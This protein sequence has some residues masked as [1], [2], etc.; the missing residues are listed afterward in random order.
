M[1]QYFIAVV[2]ATKYNEKRKFLKKQFIIKPTY[3]KLL[4]HSDIND[5]EP[6]L[7]ANLMHQLYIE[8]WSTQLVWLGDYHQ[9]NFG[10]KKLYEKLRDKVTPYEMRQVN[11]ETF[12][13]FEGVGEFSIEKDYRY[14][15]NSEKCE[16]IDFKKYLIDDNLDCLL[17]P[18]PMLTADGNGKGNGDYFNQ[19]NWR[20]VGRWK[21]DTI[22]VSDELIQET[23][24]SSRFELKE[25]DVKFSSDY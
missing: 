18:L 23:N 11:D 10:S 20:D 1:G 5:F 8:G 3:S 13:K 24:V 21:Y 4:A 7:V 22:I 19:E 9:E 17:H 2:Q 6:R 12:V 15:I 16:Y 14:L 25:I